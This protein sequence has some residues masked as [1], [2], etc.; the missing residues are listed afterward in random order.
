M[1]VLTKAAAPIKGTATLFTLDKAALAA[2]T[3]VAADA[4]FS[5]SANWKS[6]SLLYHSSIGNQHEVVKFEASQSSPTSK[7]LVSEQSRD[8]FEI[9]EIVIKDFDGGTFKV[10]RSELTTAEFDVDMT[11]VAVIPALYTRDFA[12]PNSLLGTESIN[13]DADILNSLLN[14]RLSPTQDPT[15][16]NMDQSYPMNGSSSFKIRLFISSYVNPGSGIII[17]QGNGNILGSI[18]AASLVSAIGQYVDLIVPPLG[19]QTR[20]MIIYDYLNG[21]RVTGSVLSI[22]KIEVLIN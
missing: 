14:L 5:D 21:G 13:A 16:M 9:K 20:F 12:N 10:L 2:V 4:Y 8:I 18:S 11:P 15:Y 17:Q 1:T 19:T 6:V 7:F 3:S 22:S